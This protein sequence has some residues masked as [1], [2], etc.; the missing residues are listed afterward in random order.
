RAVQKRLKR[1][2]FYSG[3]A[4]GVY[5]SET[6]DAVAR[7]QIRHALDINGRIDAVTADS[8]RV[9]P[10]AAPILPPTV[11]P[12]A[13]ALIADPNA[14][15]LLLSRERLRDYV[16]AFIVAGL[17]PEVKAELRFFGDRVDYFDDGM[18]NR[19]RI[20][21]DLEKYAQRWPERRFWLAG[22][23]EVQPQP[24]SR[25]RITFLLHFEVR[26]GPK[27][28]SGEVLKTLVLEVVG[29]DL[30]IVGVKERRPSS[31]AAPVR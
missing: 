9:K 4:D 24:E 31:P 28:A 17:A 7:Y 1:A 26:N 29:Q 6:A 2:G 22:D 11:E 18:V 14:G 21:R 13:T 23:V 5:S 15:T 8:L 19:E 3:K 25:L 27:S 20:R 12:A 10:P 16:A 30:Q